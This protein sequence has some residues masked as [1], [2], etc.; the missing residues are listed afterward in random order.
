MSQQIYV[1]IQQPE[2]LKFE[3]LGRLTVENNKGH[4]IYSP[5]YTGTWVPD[6]IH[7]PLRKAPYIVDSNNGIPGFIMDLMP[8]HWGKLLI[9]RI[10]LPQLDR[11][12]TDLDY[13]LLSQNSDRF[14]SLTI[15]D[16]KK[17]NQKAT[18]E[19]FERFENVSGFIGFV[20]KVRSGKPIDSVNFALFQTSSLGGARPKITL[21]DD[22][23]LYLAKP[24]DINDLVDTP[25]VEYLCLKF[26]AEKGFNVAEFS[27]ET[28]NHLNIDRNFLVLKRFDRT[29]NQEKMIF[30]RHPMLS[31]LS[32]LD[33]AWIST[34]TQR[35]S[36]PL[37]ANEM[38]RKNIPAEDIHELYKR[39]AFNALIG[40]DDDHPKNHAF[41]YLGNQWRLAPLFD[42]VPETKH[43]PTQLAMQIG[44]QGRVINRENLLSMCAQFKLTRVEAEQILDEV[45][46]WENE[47]REI[48]REELTS[49]DY[50]LVGKALDKNRLL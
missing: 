48:Y 27:F 5:A 50:V 45:A 20:D 6:E 41:I 33:A 29:F 18:S 36:Y 19:R 4:W 25:K 23:A 42:V 47:L 22:N 46:S 13:L 37:L 32:L 10:Y 1:Y 31:A 26:A 16:S 34:D 40:N 11:P 12:L 43:V 3:T 7:Y 38:I 44:E 17:P 30:E 35:W 15:G 28:I 24:R 39:M 8:D 49:D 2:N 21:R 14:G 9:E